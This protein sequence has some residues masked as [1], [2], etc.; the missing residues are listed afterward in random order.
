MPSHSASLSIAAPGESIW[1]ALA[2]VVAGPEWLPTVTSVQALDGAPLS[3]GARYT[4]R[5]PKLRPASWVVT[6]LEPTRRFLGRARSPGVLMVADHTI[7]ENSPGNSLVTLR[8]SFSGLLG[9]PL[10]WF[11]RSITECCLAHEMASLKLKVESRQ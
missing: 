4:I 11:F 5:Q 7:E 2:A 9:A 10:A 3:V 1:G 6:E 8:F